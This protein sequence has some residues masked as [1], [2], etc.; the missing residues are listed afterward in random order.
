MKIN[1][2]CRTHNADPQKS[3]SISTEL[4]IGSEDTISFLEI[5]GHNSG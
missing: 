4:K 2:K 5:Y 1:L 3:A